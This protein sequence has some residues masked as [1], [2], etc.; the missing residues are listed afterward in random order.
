M[1][2]LIMYIIKFVDITCK[3]TRTCTHKLC[4]Q[5]NYLYDIQMS[6]TKEMFLGTTSFVK[7][8]G[9]EINIHFFRQQSYFL[10]CVHHNQVSIFPI[11]ANMCTH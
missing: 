5:D 3:Q 4:Y 7:L 6:N 8:H 2:N 10:I 9:C 11:L 1:F